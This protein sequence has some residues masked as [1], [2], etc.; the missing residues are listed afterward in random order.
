[1]TS[2]NR[3]RFLKLGLKGAAVAMTPFD[4]IMRLLLEGSHGKSYAAG[5]SNMRYFMIHQPYSPSRWMFDLLLNPW[6][7]SKFKSNAQ[8]GTILKVGANDRYT[9]AD[10][11]L[12]R[13]PGQGTDGIY[14]PPMW[15][16]NL[17]TTTTATRQLSSLIPNM[18]HLRGINTTNPSHEI[19]KD[20]LFSPIGATKTVSAL[21]TELSADPIPA[22]A[23]HPRLIEGRVNTYIYKSPNGA[24]SITLNSSNYIKELT[25]TF[26]WPTEYAPS[27][28][29]FADAATKLS[30]QIETF[31]GELDKELAN[32]NSSYDVV[33]GS[34][35]EMRSL[36]SRGLGD[37]IQ[38]WNSLLAKYT[39]LIR[40]T[41][42]SRFP[43]LSDKVVGAGAGGGLS[44]LIGGLNSPSTD[45]HALLAPE[46]VTVRGMAELFA[47]AEFI[48]T[49]NLSSS[50]VGNHEHI[51]GLGSPY[52]RIDP[53]QHQTGSLTTTY[54]NAMM[55][56]ALGACL[57][58]FVE[59]LRNKGLFESTLIEIASEFNRSPKA[60]DGGAD[61]AFM[62]ASSMFFS[63][64]IK[65]PLV[66]GNISQQDTNGIYTGATYGN[67]APNPELGGGA[68][69]PAQRAATIAA[70][71]GVTSPVSS[72]KS[73]VKKE[74]EG[75]IVPEAGVGPG[76]IIATA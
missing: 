42:R 31:Q 64:A 18:L 34:R 49:H 9:S 12:T 17:P 35:R 22:V 71:V 58:E 3:R 41:F 63:G 20:Y 40:S 2:M 56:S 37:P 36:L 62:G 28:S 69:T 39:G 57:L 59:F 43:G 10:F 54:F 65:G 52:G 24:T 13:F 1:M 26:S 15:G 33:L 55:F 30:K 61:H 38:T 6:N 70:M 25:D 8:M 27:N 51:I 45:I 53:D 74:R 47:A 11:V 48:F 46:G 50:L 68:L 19:S 32:E 67:G 76:Q 44:H 60:A 75:K 66:I 4:L 14:M 73:A 16:F 5:S 21:A 72:A 29:P 23:L 7:D